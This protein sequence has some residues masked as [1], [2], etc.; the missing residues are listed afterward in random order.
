MT[1]FGVK[2]ENFSYHNFWKK[3][4]T[5]EVVAGGGAEAPRAAMRP[6]APPRA[7]TRRHGLADC[8]CSLL[9]RA[10]CVSIY[11][12]LTVMRFQNIFKKSQKITVD[13]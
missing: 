13:L 5:T 12:I 9:N 3:S 7:P 4:S 2:T 1:K 8:L 6:H 10:G 11:W